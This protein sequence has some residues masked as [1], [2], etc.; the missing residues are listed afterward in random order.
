MAAV[1]G[2]SL[3][4]GKCSSCS[5]R[6]L[7]PRGAHS[8]PPGWAAIHFPSWL[9]HVF[10]PV[11]VKNV[12][13]FP[14]GNRS[15]M[16]VEPVCTPITCVIEVTVCAAALVS[17]EVYI[18]AYIWFVSFFPPASKFYGRRLASL[19][20][21]FSFFSNYFTFFLFFFLNLV[22]LYLTYFTLFANKGPCS[23]S[24][25]FSRSHAWR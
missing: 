17:E 3:L 11:E 1:L 13:S 20:F 6:E 10:L 24:Y 23:Q 14:P 12:S 21:F 8:D 19:L 5:N 25:G 18:F 9:A 16:E 15:W 2:V 22:L 7:R 4:V